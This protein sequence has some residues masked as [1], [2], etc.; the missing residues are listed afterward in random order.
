MS[1]EPAGLDGCVWHLTLADRALILAKSRAN[2]LRFAVMLLFFR[3]RGR[4]PR[5]AEEVGAAA[6][7]A[8]A[9][10]LGVPIPQEPLAFESADRTLERQRAEIR[11]LFGFREATVADAASLGAW[12]RD[13]AVAQ[14]RDR[15]RLT[16]ELEARCRTLRIEPPTRERIARIVRGAVRA[17]EDRFT[18][19]IHGKLSPEVRSRLDALLQPVSG[20]SDNDANGAST[21]GAR[22]LLNFLRGDPGRAS[23]D[24]VMRELD[25]LQ[26]IRAIDLPAGLFADAL[27]H[28]IELYRQRVA[29][30]PPSDLRR[31]PEAVRITWLAAFVYL[32]G[33]A[34]TDSL[35]T[36]GRDCACDRCPG[37]AT[38]RAAGHQRNPQSQ[39]QDQPAV[40]DRQCFAGP[41]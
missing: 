34:L 1:R 31:L 11:A 5:A 25:R 15:D 22:A 29:V 14:S 4:F 9:S 24:S 13:H 38:G 8:L 20:Q 17:Y 32:R 27:P 26:A 39:R 7:A 36:A 21:S 33:R 18:A 16:A 3:D 40:R 12:L 23:L 37:G 41:A 28:E 6:I 35:R 2:R 19:T 30:Q 10:D